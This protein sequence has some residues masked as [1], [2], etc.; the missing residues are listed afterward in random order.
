[1]AKESGK[2]SETE[3]HQNYWLLYTHS[4]LSCGRIRAVAVEKVKSVWEMCVSGASTGIQ[5]NEQRESAA[6][7]LVCKLNE[8]NVGTSLRLIYMCRIKAL[9]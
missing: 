5:L 7:G 2:W 4:L 8:L 9:G 6:D 1:M 3:Q